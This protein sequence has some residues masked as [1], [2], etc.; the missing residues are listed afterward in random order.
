M[1]KFGKLLQVM[2]RRL[3]NNFVHESSRVLVHG[4]RYVNTFKHQYVEDLM[5]KK[6]P[7][8]AHTN[9]FGSH[10]PITNSSGKLANIN[11]KKNQSG[12]TPKQF[13]SNFYSFYRIFY[14]FGRTDSGRCLLAN[15]IYN[16]L[17]ILVKT[18]III[19]QVRHFDEPR[20]EVYFKFSQLFSK[21]IFEHIVLLKNYNPLYSWPK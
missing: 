19:L 11:Q 16:S 15:S 10:S 2:V 7:K 12:C 1:W 4:V 5:Q 14:Q 8:Y 3:P 21:N 17:Y 20:F 18:F 9:S 6:T 13:S